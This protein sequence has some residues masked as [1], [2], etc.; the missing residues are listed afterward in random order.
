MKKEYREFFIREEQVNSGSKADQDVNFPISH[1]VN[2]CSGIKE[3]F[4]R[5]LSKH[6][7]SDNVIKKLLLSI[8]F[9]LNPE[10]TASESEQ[11]LVKAASD[12]D[13]ALGTVHT[14]YARSVLPHQLADIAGTYAENTYGVTKNY[15]DLANG[16]TY[17][18]LTD[19][20]NSGHKFRVVTIMPKPSSK[21]VGSIVNNPAIAYTLANS[22][23]A[24]Y[25]AVPNVIN[26]QTLLDGDRL[27]YTMYCVIT[28]ITTGDVYLQVVIKDTILNQKTIL[29]P[30]YAAIEIL[31]T[32][33]KVKVEVTFVKQGSDI[34]YTYTVRSLFD[35]AIVS[36]SDY[37]PFTPKAFS[38]GCDISLPGVQTGA[39]LS[40]NHYSLELKTV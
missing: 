30:N 14:D 12:T 19:A 17:D 10:D 23:E 22:V 21:T 18:N 29:I 33:G 1:M 35:G 16:V 6:Y 25:I 27:I 4:N 37:A 3:K 9:K 2:T 36:D 13:A 20:Q 11:G 26:N 5:L 31:R 34:F 40:I 32:G 24:G 15:I 8:P 39:S 38:V 28:P 7:A